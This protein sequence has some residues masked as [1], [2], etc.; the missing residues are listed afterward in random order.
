[1]RWT[2]MLSI[3]LI[4]MASA[5]GAGHAIGAEVCAAK[6]QALRNVIVFDG[7]PSELAS[8]VPDEGGDTSASWELGY[9]Y[10]RAG[11]SGFAASMRTER[12]RTCSSALRSA[13]AN[14]RRSKRT[15][16][17]YFAN[18]RPGP[19]IG[20]ALKDL[21]EAWIAGGFTA[22]RGAFLELARQKAAAG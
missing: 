16:S 9:V 17:S 13:N 1:M 20:A 2:W 5:C 7:P 8:L 15:H 18:N 12:V 21:E 3:P 22:D 10:E 11:Q 19:A 14:T 6:S 4:A